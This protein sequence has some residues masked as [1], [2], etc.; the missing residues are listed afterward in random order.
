LAYIHELRLNG[1]SNKITSY[2]VFKEHEREYVLEPAYGK[3]T[4]RTLDRGGF[5]RACMLYLMSCEVKSSMF[6]TIESLPSHLVT[7]E[8]EFGKGFSAEDP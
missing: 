7:V 8:A 6:G 1:L 3:R 5:R 4:S 2:L